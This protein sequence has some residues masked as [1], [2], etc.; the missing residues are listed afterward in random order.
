VQGEGDICGGG[1]SDAA[2]DHEAV[3][4]LECFEG[5]G[6]GGYDRVA[7]VAVVFEHADID[8]EQCVV[9]AQ[10]GEQARRE[11]AGGRR[12]GGGG[13]G[14]LRRHTRLPVYMHRASTSIALLLMNARCNRD[15]RTMSAPSFFTKGTTLQRRVRRSD[16][17]CKDANRNAV[18]ES[19]T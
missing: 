5:G 12:G 9:T 8:L 13:A 3:R 11:A 7:A 17:R 6:G 15:S 1:N 18:L 16:A 4:A 2:V 19:G 14:T 10:G